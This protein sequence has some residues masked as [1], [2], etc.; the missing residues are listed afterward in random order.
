MF[1]N[2]YLPKKL[3]KR[4]ILL[5]FCFTLLFSVLLSA[6]FLKLSKSTEKK[7][8]M[9]DMGLAVERIRKQYLQGEN[10]GRVNRFFHGKKGTIDFPDWLRDLPV[11]FHKIQRDH[12][13]WHVMIMDY[14]D[15]RYILLRDYTVF[16]STRLHPLLL[17]LLVLLSS[18]L[19]SFILVWITLYFVI[20]PIEKLEKS[21]R[22]ELSPQRQKQLA[23]NYD[24]NEIGQL[25]QTF[26]EVYDRL[27]QALEREKLFTADVSH[28]LR[29]PL[30]V[31]LSSVELLL[32]HP[33]LSHHKAQPRLVK[34]EQAVAQILQR[35][36]VYLALARQ[37]TSS[38]NQFK[39]QSIIEIAETVI[40]E[41]LAFSLTCKVT[42]SLQTNQIDQLY[43]ADFC[44]TILSNLVKNAIEYAGEQSTV[45]I[46]L[47]SYGF[48]VSDDGIGIFPEFQPRIFSV[49]TGSNTSTSQHLGLGLSLV[50][51]ICDYLNWKIEFLSEQGQGTCFTIYTSAKDEKS[52]LFDS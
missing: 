20:N 5:F 31:I 29:T 18:L 51:R 2:S 10:V 3:K 1:I 32:S 30:M 21:V 6:V 37:T 16:E 42:L 36:E 44:Y 33:E 7:L 49:F 41:N 48:D 52:K 14:P 27:T 17:S 26:D 15:Q 47:Y 23:N 45:T 11:G 43:P 4:I 12:L 35:L 25:A 46:H 50:Q 34:I 28:E 13:I 38:I 9:I 19:L 39:Q 8:Q 22:I 40:S 24:N